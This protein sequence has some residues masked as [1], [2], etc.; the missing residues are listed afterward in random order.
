MLAGALIPIGLAGG[1]SG[2][3]TR[4][5]PC[6]YTIQPPAEFVARHLEGISS[7][8]PPEISL[9]PFGAQCHYL[10][11]ATGETISS[12]L[13]IWPTAAIVGG[14]AILLISAVGVV[15]TARRTG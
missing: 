7:V 15:V 9:F 1:V 14:I 10:A 2:L 11:T 5:P 8:G 3:V 6:A 13:P 12:V 4:R